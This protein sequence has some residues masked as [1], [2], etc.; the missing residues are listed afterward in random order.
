MSSATP[1]N[2]L[3]S[4]IEVV[5]DDQLE[6]PD[7]ASRATSEE[8]ENNVAALSKRQPWRE[9]FQIKQNVWLTEELG[10]RNEDE[11]RIFSECDDKK[12]GG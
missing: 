6:S 12:L 5:S 1:Q 2:P 8:P 10:L 3:P 7:R 9:F 11:V 4:K